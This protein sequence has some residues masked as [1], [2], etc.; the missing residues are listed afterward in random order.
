MPDK[1]AGGRPPKYRKEFVQ[2][3]LDYFDVDVVERI[4]DDPTGKGGS[5]TFYQAMRVPSIEGFAG[6][7]NVH[8]DTIYNWA[9]EKYPE[10]YPNEKLRGT[11]KYPKFSDA[12]SRVQTIQEGMVFEY[13]MAGMLDKSLAAMYFTNKLGFRNKSE[14]ENKE[15]VTHKWED[16]TE[17]Q[18]DAAIKARKDRTA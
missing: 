16:M 2:K 8:K 15:E 3:L 18:L 4:V 12:L 1:H 17:E 14:V 13:G 9:L 10:D 7:I 11:L 5:R 6:S